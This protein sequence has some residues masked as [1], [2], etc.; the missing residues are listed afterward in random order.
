MEQFLDRPEF[1]S[2]VIPF[3]SALLVYAGL[4]KFTAAAWICALFAG[5]LISVGL[6][7]GATI[8]PLTGTRKII[9]LVLGSLVLAA[10]A[11]LLIRQ[12]KLQRAVAP[13]L[14]ILALLW[15]FWKVVARME[16]SGIL[17]FLA[18][19]LALAIWLAWTFERIARD[20][21][22]LHGAGLGLLLGTGLSATA[23]ASALL[24]Q[25][26]L[27]L[28]AATG[29]VLLA[30]VLI[31]RAARSANLNASIGTLPYVLAATLFGLAAVV[32]AR[33]PWYALIPLASI[34]L[35]ASL[36]PVKTDSPFLAALLYSL[37][38]LV[39]A[40]ATAFWVWQAGASNSSGY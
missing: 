11:P 23:G 34:P 20:D 15:I 8:T 25:L 2:A 40:L 39:I 1:Q 18:G 14:T 13:I 33:M 24:G 10:L 28:A 12:I 21:A 26:A 38:G 37:P 7:N 3:G 30:W 35:A 29:G 27:A 17:L 36:V 32:F 5:F 22:R 16:F 31:G 9:L 4:R 6:I 19:G